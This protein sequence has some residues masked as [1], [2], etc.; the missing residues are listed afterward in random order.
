MK[1][2][3]EKTLG[4][5]IA[6]WERLPKDNSTIEEEKGYE[7]KNKTVEKIMIDANV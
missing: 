7:N 2:E 5:E 6:D 4:E 3:D 1:V